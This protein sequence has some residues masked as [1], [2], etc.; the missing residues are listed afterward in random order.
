MSFE[1]DPNV[2]FKLAADYISRGFKVVKLHYF[3]PDGSCTCP[4]VAHRPGGIGHSQ[5]GK[6]P[7]FKQWQHTAC[8]DEEVL[9]EWCEGSPFN[10]GVQ[11]GPR[12]GIIDVEWDNEKAMKVAVEMGLTRI[13]TPTFTSGRSEHRIFLWDD[14]LM[15]VGK[16]V[17][18]VGGLEFRVGVGDLG[19]QSVFP[20]SWHWSGAQY[21]WKEGFGLDDVPIVPLPREVLIHVVNDAGDVASNSNR[22]KRTADI[23]SKMRNGAGEGDRHDFL[24]GV[25]C[26]QVFIHP[27]YQNPV[28]QDDI[29]EGVHH[30]NLARC[31]PA[32]DRNEIAG[33]VSWACEIRRK[34]EAAGE[35]VP[36]VPDDIDRLVASPEVKAMQEEARKKIEERSRVHA[37]REDGEVDDKAGPPA[38]DISPVTR[39]WALYGLATA[40]KF[41]HWEEKMGED[42]SIQRQ[43]AH[44]HWVP[45]NWKIQMLESDPPEI[46]LVV[47]NWESHP[48]NGRVRMPLADF[49]DPRVVA[50]RVFE[51]TRRFILDSDPK[52][53]HAIWRGQT[54]KGSGAKARPQIDGLAVM[55]MANKAAVDDIPVG[56]S[57][58]RYAVV[59]GW[60]LDAFR[61][62]TKPRDEEKPEPNESGRPCWVKPGELWFK[63]AKTWEDIERMHDVQIGERLKI[64][65]M[66]CHEI[67]GK[68]AV[69]DL[70]EVRHTFGGVRHSYVVF[71]ADWYA[72]VERL[73]SGRRVESDAALIGG[74]PPEINY[75][76]D[77]ENDVM[78]SS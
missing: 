11:L 6:H 20:P 54:A 29:V 58:L 34:W 19:S 74:K 61:K 32:K 12:S 36:V 48:G 4:D 46:V 15:S 44:T 38:P 51:T 5:A 47:P 35:S 28:V 71:D 72:A 26:R 64:K 50:K 59:S 18:K 62:A 3:R 21:K 41:T 45:G 16:A 75:D 40:E 65:H 14:S 66:I 31:R 68:P 73:A 8:D 55:L 78:P 49:L 33:I 22:E 43:K 25:A 67:G 69:Q 2:M 52:E 76:L 42:K 39:A 9:A 23:R 60:L 57:G 37:T 77:Q 53:W 63:W 13:E 70:P 1:F 27:A 24:L 30:T 10:L 56:T 7:R 17:H